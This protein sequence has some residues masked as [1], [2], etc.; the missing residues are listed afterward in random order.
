MWD[1][2]WTK[3][4]PLYPLFHGDIIPFVTAVGITGNITGIVVEQLQT[5]IQ[6]A[7]THTHTHTHTGI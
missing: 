3:W 1:L 6:R 7:C 5:N 2:W 4:H